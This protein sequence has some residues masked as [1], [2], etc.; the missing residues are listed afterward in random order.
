[1]NTKMIA[2]ITAAFLIAQPCMAAAAPDNAYH[3]GKPSA[4]KPSVADLESQVAY[5]R[6]F[7][8]AVWAM[9]LVNTHRLR[10]G[11]MEGNQTR[12]N[13]IVSFSKPATSRHELLTANNTTPYVTANMDLRQGPVVIDIPARTDKAVLFGQIINAWGVTLDSFGPG[14]IDKG[15]GGRYLMLPPGH[16][17]PVPDGFIAVHSDTF[18]IALAARSIHGPKGTDAEAVEYGRTI[19]VYPLADAANPPPNRIVDG[20]PNAAYTLP[21]YD[22]RYFQDLH[23]VVSVEPVKA[24]DKVMMGMLASIGIERGKPFAPQG[25]VKAA[26]ER[27]IV[28]A[29]FYMQKRSATFQSKNPF[30]PDRHWGAGQ[31]TD[32]NR[33]FEFETDDAVLIDNR[34]DIFHAASYFPKKLLPGKVPVMYLVAFSDNKGRP[35]AAGGNYRIRIPADIPAA[36]FWSIVPYDESTWAFVYNDMARV[37]L[38]TFDKDQLQV[39]ADGSVDI[40]F[41]ASAP[42][43][44]KSNWI[45]MGKSVAVPQLRLYGVGDALWDGSFK[46]PDVERVN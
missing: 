1:M 17:Q 21:R 23:D 16:A 34:A 30:W 3:G 11:I 20:Y 5:Q 4:S 36:Q 25:K 40:Y 2:A 46:M 13:D 31:I 28:D 29:Y 15:A 27:A 18:R 6:A 42:K 35:F 38:S 26:M 7:E 39:N 10:L 33:G 44:G 9:P 41:G 22:L 19:R 37:G 45:P 24:R 14:G 32:P 43:Q 8:A 12:D